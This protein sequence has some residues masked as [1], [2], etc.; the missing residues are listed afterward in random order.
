[1]KDKFI[2]IC[3]YLYRISQFIG[4]VIS[5]FLLNY[6]NYEKNTHSMIFWGIILLL[7]TIILKGHN[8][9]CEDKENR[10]NGKF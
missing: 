2:D 5:V 8:Y 7:N 3:Y 4:F 9:E 6:F 10:I 1:M